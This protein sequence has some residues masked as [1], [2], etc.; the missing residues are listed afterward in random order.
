M[1]HSICFSGRYCASQHM[2]RRHCIAHTRPCFRCEGL[3]KEH[4]PVC[5]AFV[6]S[7]AITKARPRPPPH[8]PAA[9]RLATRCDFTTALLHSQ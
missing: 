3:G 5:H 4:G 9:L 1:H 6:K 7:L 8:L 2:T